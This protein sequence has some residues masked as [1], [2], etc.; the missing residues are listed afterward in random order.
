MTQHRSFPLAEQSPGRRRVVGG[1]FGLSAAA[2]AAPVLT[3]CGG[4]TPAS[5]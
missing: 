3:A 5:R 4:R 2:L 1:L